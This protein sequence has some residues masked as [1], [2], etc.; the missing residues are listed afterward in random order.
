MPTTKKRAAKKAL[1][2]RFDPRWIKDPPPPFF[3]N[4][5]RAVQREIATAKREFQA[6]VKEILVRGQ[7]Q[8]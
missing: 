2:L 6:R 4:L 7:R 8:G 1:V 3:R 5:D